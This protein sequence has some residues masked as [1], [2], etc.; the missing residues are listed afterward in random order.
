[1]IIV[2]V[3]VFLF[4]CRSTQIMGDSMEDFTWQRITRHARTCVVP[5]LDKVYAY[6]TAH[7][8]I[9]VNYIFD[10]VKVELGGVEC[11]LEQLDE[12]QKVSPPSST[13]LTTSER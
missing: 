6:S 12:G 7:A 5:P 10:L 3:H 11:R 9:C 1:M 13:V 2:I 4:L 8:T